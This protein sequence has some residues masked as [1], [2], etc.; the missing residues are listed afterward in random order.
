MISFELIS[1]KQKKKKRLVREK[2]RHQEKDKATILFPFSSLP[3]RDE[4]VPKKLKLNYRPQTEVQLLRH[5]PQI[6]IL[7]RNKK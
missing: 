5:I 7:S 3:Q 6:R 4:N 1:E 2:S